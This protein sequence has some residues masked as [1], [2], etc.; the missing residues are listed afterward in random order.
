MKVILCVP[1]LAD[2]DRHGA[3]A[4]TIVGRRYS[5]SPLS[6]AFSSVPK[7]AVLMRVRGA[8]T[9]GRSP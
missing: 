1:R 2:Q 9:L 8:G 5:I 7:V 6:T 4:G 3:H